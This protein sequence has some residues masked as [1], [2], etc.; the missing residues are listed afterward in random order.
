MAIG[1]N[2]WGAETYRNKLEKYGS[3]HF[4]IEIT[5]WFLESANVLVNRTQL[6]LQQARMS[7]SPSLLG[8]SL[9]HITTLDQITLWHF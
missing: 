2:I 5:P 4:L 1:T 8:F 3:G 7:G 9:L 6:Q